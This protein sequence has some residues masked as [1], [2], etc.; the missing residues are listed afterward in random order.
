MGHGV[1]T[2]KPTTLA[3]SAAGSFVFNQLS[4]WKFSQ[5]KK[6][7]HAKLILGSSHMSYNQATVM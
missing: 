1:L 3:Q 4:T 7:D 6:T 2:M 5:G